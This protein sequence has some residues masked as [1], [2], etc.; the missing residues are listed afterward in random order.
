VI[1]F[2]SVAVG[3]N[4]GH[5][6]LGTLFRHLKNVFFSRNYRSKYA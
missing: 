2:S 1:T 4:W 3:D 6:L 5:A